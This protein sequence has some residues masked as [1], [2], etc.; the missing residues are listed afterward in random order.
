MFDGVD[1]AVKGGE[2]S[3][4]VELPAGN[5]LPWL[6]NMFAEE[7]AIAKARADITASGLLSLAGEL[8]I[9]IPVPAPAPSTYILPDASN[10]MPPLDAHIAVGSES[11]QALKVVGSG[12]PKTLTSVGA[13]VG[14]L[15]STTRFQ[16]ASTT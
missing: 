12:W 15:N 1:L 5:E 4:S 8:Y 16:P 13:V 14:L 6:M 9:P 11:E 3:T 10:A 7:N 2:Y